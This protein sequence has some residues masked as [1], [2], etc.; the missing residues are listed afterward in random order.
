MSYD[1]E[2]KSFLSELASDSP[3]PGGGTA[4]AISGAMGISLL[5]MVLGVYAKKLKV[6]ERKTSILNRVEELKSKSNDL[7]EL[8]NNDNVAFDKVMEAY[9]LPKATEDE[10]KKRT[11]MIQDALKGATMSPF[12]ILRKVSE[13][14]DTVESILENSSDS[15][16]SDLLES[17]CL[18]EA[19]A[20][21]AL[22]N[23]KI[24]LNSINDEAFV[25]NIANESKD[26]F[27]RFLGLLRKV[28]EASE[29]K[30]F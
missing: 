17:L 20:S 2:L 3:T 8:A 12:R 15:T 5:A 28:R 4:S 27:E 11:A 30:L 23:I 22:Y 10:K 24:N 14:Y 1:Q 18:L 6:Q 16:L 29:K 9:K 13:T 21:G 19:A 26:I 25:K 7:L